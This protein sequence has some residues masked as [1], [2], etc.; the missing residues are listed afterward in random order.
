MTE[1]VL[2]M[3]EFPTVELEERGAALL[4]TLYQVR[5]EEVFGLSFATDVRNQRNLVVLLREG[6][7]LNICNLPCMVS[8]NPP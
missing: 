7:C 2:E 1:A 5:I 6:D 8:P 4:P 3:Q